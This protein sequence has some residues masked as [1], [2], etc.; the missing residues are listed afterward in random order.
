LVLLKG[1]LRR[2]L[3]LVGEGDIAGRF[4]PCDIRA[5]LV[6]DAEKS[7]HASTGDFGKSDEEG[8]DAAVLEICNID[9]IED[10]I[11]AEDGIEDHG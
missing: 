11:A 9:G 1:I 5:V 3:D 10:P 8:H 7:P 4:K 6:F 2:G